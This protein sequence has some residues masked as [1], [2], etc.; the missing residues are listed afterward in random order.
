MRRASILP[1]IPSKSIS[2]PDATHSPTANGVRRRPKRRRLQYNYLRHFTKR[3]PRP[4]QA[5][6]SRPKRLRTPAKPMSGPV[7]AMSER[8]TAESGHGDRIRR[9]AKPF[10]RCVNR[11]RSRAMVLR[12][13]T[14]RHRTRVKALRTR[15][16]A[17]RTRPN[18]I[19]RRVNASFRS[20]MRFAPTPDSS[21]ESEAGIA[22]ARSGFGR[23]R[24]A[25]PG[26]RSYFVALR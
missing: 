12:S 6:R 13:R 10:R 1:I 17:S 19:A 4:A 25:F 26:V 23:L 15:T 9:R 3:L 16:S 5:P 24:N 22:V 2:L 11:L 8:A 20:V 18:A 14:T 7:N 21:A